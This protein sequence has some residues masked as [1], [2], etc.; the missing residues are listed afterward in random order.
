MENEQNL[1]PDT[2]YL[3]GKL[4]GL[5]VISVT[6]IKVL[7]LVEEAVVVTIVQEE[8]QSEISLTQAELGEARGKKANPVNTESPKTS[9]EVIQEL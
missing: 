1:Y 9:P 5:R 3:E 7:Y 6:G 8:V 2:F 4:I